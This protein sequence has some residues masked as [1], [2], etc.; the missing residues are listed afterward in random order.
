[1]VAVVVM[2]FLLHVRSAFVALV[3]VPVGIVASLLV[4]YLLGI[5]ANVMSLGGIAIAIGVMVDASLV[6]VENAHKHIERLREEQKVEGGKVEGGKVEDEQIENGG[7]S[8]V[9]D[10]SRSI[11]QT[12]D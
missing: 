9:H 6:M 7:G 10:N 12:P 3:T 2:L 5:N 1:V 4:M 11:L 8:S